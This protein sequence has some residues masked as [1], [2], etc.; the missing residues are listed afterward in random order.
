MACRSAACVLGGVRL[1]SSARTTFAKTGP[2]IKRN[3]RFPVFAS[4]SII[5]VPMIS[6]GIRSGVNCIRLKGSSSIFANVL[7]SSVFAKPGTPTRRQCPCEKRAISS[8]SITSLCPIILFFSSVNMFSR[9]DLR[10]SAASKS[11]SIGLVSINF[12]SIIY[13]CS[14]LC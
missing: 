5:S 3:A 14:S 4:S 11:V 1:I 2:L 7:M 9:A 8:W 12:P 13:S 6:D 10:N